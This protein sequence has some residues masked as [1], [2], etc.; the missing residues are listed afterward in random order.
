MTDDQPAIET[1]GLTKRYGDVT[2][3]DNL[4]LTVESGEVFGFLG[5]N[6]AGKSTVLNTLLDFVSPTS[7]EASIMGLDVAADR[8]TIHRRIG[9]VPE[10]YGLYD[11]LSGRR[12]VEL[13]I[14]LKDATDDPD[15][16][17]D[18][19]GLDPDDAQRPAGEYSTGMGQ[20]LALAMALV[21]SPDLLLLDEPTS[22]LD[23]NGARELREIILA[24]NERGAT[25]FFSSHVLEQVEAVADRVG[26]L[27][28]GSM[29]TV[30]TIEGLRSEMGSG[31]TVSLDVADDPTGDLP[32]ADSLS[33]VDDVSFT[34]GTLTATCRRPAA[35][36]TLLDEVRA[37]T[38]VS[39]VRIDE[40]S[41][42]DLFADY[43]EGSDEPTQTQ[44]ASSAAA[45]D[46][47]TPT[48]EVE[49]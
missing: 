4:D 30:D 26:I 10:D 22:G 38:T 9:V 41:L 32:D 13:A 40:S 31:A 2:A 20:R 29:I 45:R 37:V 17:L 39:D 47:A 46:G 23:P 24:E 49:G 16:L 36:L 6:G 21:G 42:E 7:G 3:V 34:D 12:H 33:H 28:D 27:N 43:T 1:R 8:E 48:S 15:T 35:K 14:E 5:P 18:R 11:R 44:H 25:V 19:V